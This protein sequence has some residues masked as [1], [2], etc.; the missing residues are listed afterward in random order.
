MKIKNFVAAVKNLI[1]DMRYGAFLGG[2]VTTRFGNTGAYDTV[3][4]DYPAL[5][6]IFREM[7]DIG[8]DDVLV[9]V[10]C[11]KGRVIN[12]W[13]S[14]GL[15]N[16]IY[17]L[18]LDPVIGEAT[19]KRLQKY[20]NVTVVVGDAIANLPSDGSVFYLYNP[21][22]AAILQLFIQ[23]VKNGGDRKYTIIY[24]NPEHL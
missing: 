10:G 14:M 16:R 2:N 22:N 19:R 15:K 13:L 1:R 5:E 8:P 12:L 9:D 3:N 24:Y 18:E 11:G 21:F 4:S 17:G 6:K 23:K 7:V 20:S